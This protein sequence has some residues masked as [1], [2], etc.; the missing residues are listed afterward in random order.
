MVLA[1]AGSAN[2]M[3]AGDRRFWF[4]ATLSGTSSWP[5][6]EIRNPKSERN[7]KAEARRGLVQRLQLGALTQGRLSE[8][9]PSSVA[10]RPRSLS[11]LALLLR[12]DRRGFRISGF[13]RIS[14]FGLRASHMPPF[15]RKQRRTRFSFGTVSCWAICNT[16]SRSIE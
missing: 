14:V 12:V 15:H 3:T 8:A 10:R 4:L 2:R 7:P 1:Q 16:P 9:A 13:F 6:F 11:A 5:K